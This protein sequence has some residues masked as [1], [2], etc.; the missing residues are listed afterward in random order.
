MVN[1]DTSK[2]I[3]KHYQVINDFVQQNKERC[4]VLNFKNF[5][6]NPLEQAERISCFLGIEINKAT[7]QKIKKFVISREK[8]KKE[9]QRAILKEFFYRTKRFLKKCFKNP[10][11]YRLCDFLVN[12][13]ELPKKEA[14]GV[15]RICVG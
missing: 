15:S 2:I 10:F 3:E 6:N 12:P 5:V 11:K 1:K 7:G 9:K 4:Y 13:H 8:I 14:V